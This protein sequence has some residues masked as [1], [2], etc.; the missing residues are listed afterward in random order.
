METPFVLIEIGC[1]KFQ[2]VT[3]WLSKVTLEKQTQNNFE[4]ISFFY[5]LPNGALTEKPA[6]I[7]NQYSEVYLQFRVI[8]VFEFQW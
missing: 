1:R 5:Y 3:R 4:V 8:K 2:P 6:R 7:A